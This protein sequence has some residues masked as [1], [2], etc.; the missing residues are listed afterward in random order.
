MLLITCFTISKHLYIVLTVN[1]IMCAM[2]YDVTYVILLYSLFMSFVRL[3]ST[4]LPSPLPIFRS[5]LHSQ[6]QQISF[7]LLLLP[8]TV[9]ASALLVNHS[10]SILST[11][12]AHFNRLFT[13]LLLKLSFLQYIVTDR[14]PKIR[15]RV[16]T[17]CSL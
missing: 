1:D 17:P 13:S 8:F 5:P 6:S 10:S 14:Q 2:I 9:S 16:R 15:G 11:C 7:L 3:I 12:P 4:S